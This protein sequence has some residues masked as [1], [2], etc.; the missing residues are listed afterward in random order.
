MNQSYAATESRIHNVIDAINTR[1][2]AKVKAITREF[3]VSYKS[4][5]N[6]LTETPTKLEVRGLHN[7][8]LTPNQDLAISLFY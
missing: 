2:N 6:R 3:D 7:R 5:R 4:L 1:Q 8:L